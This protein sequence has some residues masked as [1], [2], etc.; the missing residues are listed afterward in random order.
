MSK[1]SVYSDPSVNMACLQYNR[2]DLERKEGLFIGLSYRWYMVGIWM[3]LH[4]ICATILWVHAF[5]T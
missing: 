2:L 4:A 1:E 3:N 5:M